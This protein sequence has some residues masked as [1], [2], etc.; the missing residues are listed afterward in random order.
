MSQYLHITFTFSG[1]IAS[2]AKGRSQATLKPGDDALDLP[3]LPIFASMET[4]S[5]LPP[6]P[7]LG[8]AA[9]TSAI[10]I[11]DGR[12]NSQAFPSHLVVG[13]RIVSAACQQA[14]DL[15]IPAC[16]EQGFRKQRCIVTG[17]HRGQSRGDQMAGGV[18]NQRQL[19]E[20]PVAVTAVAIASAA[21]VM[22]GTNGRLQPGGVDSRL[23]VGVD[24][25]TP[26]S[27]HEDRSEQVLKA[28]FFASRWRAWKRVVWCGILV[29]PKM[30]F[31][32][33]RSHRSTTIPRSSVLKNCSKARIAMSWCWV[34][35]FFE[36]LDEYAGMAWRATSTAFLTNATGE[37]VATRRWGGIHT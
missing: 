24:Q 6:E 23:G 35:S 33:N 19:R 10:Q 7:L 21:S 2:T 26:L 9:C 27:I 4:L 17:S 16:L 29:S 8:P 28:P 37:R 15:Q 22:G 1:A 12:A 31:R 25:S 11:D 3:A 36:Y 30:F 34:K 14:V 5:H 18:A 13:L 20:L 32:S